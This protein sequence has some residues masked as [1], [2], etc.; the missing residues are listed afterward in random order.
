MTGLRCERGRN[1][2]K[3]SLAFGA[4]SNPEDA[5]ERLGNIFDNVCGWGKRSSLG[6]AKVE[7]TVNLLTHLNSEGIYGGTVSEPA[8]I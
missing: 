7:I 5:V 6:S 4:F 2:G 1:P 8:L 3:E